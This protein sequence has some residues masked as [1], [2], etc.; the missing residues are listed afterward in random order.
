AATTT[1]TTTSTTTTT[2][3]T[4]TTIAAKVRKERTFVVKTAVV[5]KETVFYPDGLVDEY[6]LF[7]YDPT[8]Q[9]LLSRASYDP[10]RVDPVEKVLSEYGASGKLAA[11][12]T[13]GSD[14]SL[15]SRREVA[16]SE[17]KNYPDLLLSERGLDAKNQVQ[18][19]STYE[20]DKAGHRSAW[21]AFD[22]KGALKATTTY[23]YDA[24]GRLL[25]IELRNGA[26]V[27]TGS[28][29]VEYSADGNSE[30]RS[31]LAADGSLQK[32]EV[33]LQKDGKASRFE[34]HR[35]DG[36]LAEVSDYTLGPLGERLAT[37]TTDGAGKVREKKSA[38][39]A[40]REDQK[41]EV[42]YE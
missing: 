37:A 10:S 12:V 20:Y 36:S 17:D 41:I 6:T 31:Y 38:E 27:G 33:T 39:Y 9:K 23:T 19:S 2:T 8:M 15:K 35:A 14:G 24:K 4:T 18:Y 13:Y 11:E 7:S 16:W 42:Y 40:V 28:I 1:T 34:I 5:L 25:L 29:K 3:T 30:K 26:N 21:R 22:A 32:F